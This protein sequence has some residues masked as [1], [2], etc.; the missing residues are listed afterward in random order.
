[1]QSNNYWSSTT[2]A[3][4]TDNAWNV[5]MNNGSVYN[6]NKTNNNYVWPVR[7]DNDALPL[8]SYENVYRQYLKCRRNK[9]GTINA[10]KFEV[11]AEE[12][13]L[14][15]KRQLDEKSYYPSR[16]VCFMVTR[17]KSREIFAADFRDRIVHHILVDYLE[18]IWEPQF[19]FDSYACRKNKGIHAGVK[20]LQGFIRK[21]TSNGSSRAYYMQLDIANFF[22]SIDK[23]ILY[24][25]IEQKVSDEK[26]L[27][28]AKIIIHHD[29]TKDYI[30]KGDGDYLKKITPHKS[31]FYTGKGKG[32]PIGNLTSQFFANVYLNQLD[33]FIKH[34]LKCRLYLRYCD[35]FVMLAQE[36]NTLL[37]W[38]DAIDEFLRD[39]LK[40]RL[41]HKRQSLQPVS[42]GIDFLGYI[43]RR[44]Y[45]LIRRRVVNNLK[46]K[47]ETYKGQLIK[48]ESPYIRILYDYQ[49]L[50]K[51]CA[52]LASY[53]G[54]FRWANS[55]RLTTSL[56]QKY[57]F[58][59]QYFHFKGGGFKAMYKIPA[60]IPSLRLQ[61]RFFKTRFPG[62][63]L[64]F[65]VGRYY[66][67]Y[68]GDEDVATLLR[69][70]KINVSS[71]RRVQYGFPVRLE[72]AYISALK[73]Y[74]KTVTVI[75]EGDKYFTGVKT[76]MP[77]FSL[78]VEN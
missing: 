31:L 75:R 9:R 61:Y 1:M 64:L 53:F 63:V 33:Q 4:N 32:L 5:N 7:G 22:M 43:V 24:S 13:L 8:F 39:R 21:V 57:V 60:G 42:N 67:F 68:Q 76:R 41:N 2:N 51:L 52:T 56:I 15:L 74:G 29:C 77:T 25:R 16:S 45:V 10:L 48:K 35:D 28:L 65:Q 44:D 34:H 18:K 30:L 66:Q 69:L 23:D 54:H 47:L 70:K 49:L 11:N 27:W 14:D 17:P 37:T 40:L 62:D 19:I 71:N 20:R 50:E 78:R 3:N 59:K 55:H 26:V 36:K 73:R 58:L 46:A 72:K 6:Y 38:K 12:S